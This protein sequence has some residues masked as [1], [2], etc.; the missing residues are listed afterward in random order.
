MATSMII[1]G[2]SLLYG[3]S[4]WGWGS[5]GN[6]LMSANRVLSKLNDMIRSYVVKGRTSQFSKDE[7]VVI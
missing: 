3:W 4:S 1:D 2:Q 5:D 7:D 6:V